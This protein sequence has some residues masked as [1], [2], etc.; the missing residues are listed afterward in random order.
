MNNQAIAGINM[1]PKPNIKAAPIMARDRFFWVWNSPKQAYTV[2]EP[3]EMLK[4]YIKIKKKKILL[5]GDLKLTKN[6]LRILK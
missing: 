1:A 6:H 4:I 2:A 5:K 3:P